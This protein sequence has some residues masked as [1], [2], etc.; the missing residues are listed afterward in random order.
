MGVRTGSQYLEGLRDERKFFVNGDLVSD[1]TDYPGFA[2]SAHEL[3]RVYDY[4]HDPEYAETLTYPSPRDGKP[5]SRI[6]RTHDPI[7][8]TH[9]RQRFGPN[10]CHR[11]STYR[12]K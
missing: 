4:Q 3:A 5:V 2:R 9:K 7:L 12:Q 1:V 10:S 6:W 8:G 11:R